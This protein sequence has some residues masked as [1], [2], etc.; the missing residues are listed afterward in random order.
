MKTV[1]RYIGHNVIAST[2]TVLIVLLAIFSFFA[3]I[4][5]LE[6]VGRGSYTLLGA[7]LVVGL[8]LPGLAYDLFPIAALLGALLGLGSMMERI[9]DE[10][11]PVGIRIRSA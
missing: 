5:E 3:F 7:A 8:G 6:D 2:L 10:S 11:L 1:D 9:L 4:E